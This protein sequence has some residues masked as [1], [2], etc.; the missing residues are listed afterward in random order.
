MADSDRSR[1]PL[2]GRNRSEPRGP[3]QPMRQEL[4]FF[5]SMVRTYASSDLAFTEH[6]TPSV[7]TSVGI[8]PVGTLNDGKNDEYESTH[9][10]GQLARS[11]VSTSNL[12]HH[13]HQRLPYPVPPRQ[14]TPPCSPTLPCPQ[15]QTMHT[16]PL[17]QFLHL[18]L[19][20]SKL[21][22]RPP[23]E[24]THPMM[25]PVPTGLYLN[26]HWQEDKDHY[27]NQKINGLTF[28]RSIRQSAFTQKLDIE[29]FVI[30]CSYPWRLY[31]ISK[32]TTSG[33]ASW[34]M[35]ENSI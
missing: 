3:A 22:N 16:E 25:P 33:F 15:T 34:L 35:V 12:H 2:P 24:V 32:P 9:D 5:S 4:P 19:V 28:P 8:K 13:L 26:P 11:S 18:S 1:S 14:A 7:S 20:H 17:H 30:L 21:P 31:C 10:A 27:D 29:G 6:V 23:Q